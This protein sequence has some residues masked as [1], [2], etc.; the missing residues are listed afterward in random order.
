M[1][2]FA[3]IV[4]RSLIIACVAASIGL[5]LN[6]VSDKALPWVYVPPKELVLHGVRVKLID[7]KEA[8]RLFD[9]PETVFVDNRHQEDYRKGHVKGAFFL[10]PA[11]KE[12]QFPVVQALLSENDVLILY[13]Y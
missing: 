9:R 11:E 13:C 3:G 8:R 5:G 10:D 7:E 2:Q 1:R 6:F 4:V 12:K